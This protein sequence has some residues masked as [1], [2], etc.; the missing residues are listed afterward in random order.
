MKSKKHIIALGIFAVLF[1]I[2]LLPSGYA[3]ANGNKGAKN[4]K[5]AAD[6][7]GG[8]IEGVWKIVRTDEQTFPYDPFEGQIPGARIQLYFCF[9]AEKKLLLAIELKGM[10]E[11]DDSIKNGLY[12]ITEQDTTYDISANGELEITEGS[13]VETS[14]YTLSGDMLKIGGDQYFEAVRVSSPTA[15]QVQA[16]PKTN[17]F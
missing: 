12:R 17:S 9:T 1:T 4:N 3:Q 14:P 13:S 8:G 15:A 10:P 6:T 16:A 5:H 2:A 7:G 11:E